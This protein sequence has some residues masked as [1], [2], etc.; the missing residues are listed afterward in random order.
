MRE[1]RRK[2]KLSLRPEENTVINPQGLNSTANC[3]QEENENP[4]DDQ[5]LEQRQ[6]NTGSQAKTR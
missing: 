5:V 2:K 1:R 4:Q 3:E 6:K